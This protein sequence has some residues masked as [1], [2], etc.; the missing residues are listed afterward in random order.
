MRCAC[1]GI[2][3]PEDEDTVWDWYVDH[4]R[5][6]L[7]RGVLCAS[8]NNGIEKLGDDLAGIRRAA[9]YLEEHARRGGHPFAVEPPERLAAPISAV[10]ERC[11][12]LFKQGTPVDQVVIILRLVPEDVKQIYRLWRHEDGIIM[13]V[14]RHRFQIVKEPR[15]HVRCMCGYE[16]QNDSLEAAVDQVNAHVKAATADHAAEWARLK[17]E[18]VS[19]RAEIARRDEAERKARV[20][21]D[22]RQRAEALKSAVP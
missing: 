8:C 2:Q 5:A 11:F 4:D 10:M 6:G 13:P 15:P 20:A 14:S 12:A 3:D 1:C 9:M 21:E 7:I 22:M 18:E 16:A 19:R 17:E